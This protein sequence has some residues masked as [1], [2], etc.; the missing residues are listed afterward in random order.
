MPEQAREKRRRQILSDETSNGL[1][2]D[3]PA[4]ESRW[5]PEDPWVKEFYRAPGPRP[6]ENRR[7]E[8]GRLFQPAPIRDIVG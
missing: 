3:T 7:E 2:L 4:N 8:L 5:P 1:R 6:Q